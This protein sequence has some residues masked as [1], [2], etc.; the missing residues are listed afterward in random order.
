MFQ[1]AVRNKNTL[2]VF[3]DPPLKYAQCRALFQQDYKDSLLKTNQDVLC[4]PLLRDEQNECLVS[5]SKYG[6]VPRFIKTIGPGCPSG[7]VVNSWLQPN[8]RKLRRKALNGV[9]IRRKNERPRKIAASQNALDVLNWCEW[10]SG[11]ASCE[12]DRQQVFTW[13][14]CHCYR[15]ANCQHLPR[16]ARLTASGIASGGGRLPRGSGICSGPG[17]SDWILTNKKARDRWGDTEEAKIRR[18]CLT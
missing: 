6:S 3:S 17:R 15:R 8:S 1:V 13:C 9:L 12:P 16:K 5:T 18:D 11:S 4:G 14:L 10:S 7:K 2:V